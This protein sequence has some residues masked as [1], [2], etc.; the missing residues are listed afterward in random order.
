MLERLWLVCYINTTLAYESLNT[1]HLLRVQLAYAHIFTR[2]RETHTCI[3]PSRT[4]HI[5]PQ[6]VFALL[7]KHE[8]KVSKDDAD[9]VSDLRYTWRSLRKAAL[10]ASERLL[11][12]QPSMQASLEGEVTA[13]VFEADAFVKQWTE[14][15]PM[16]PGLEPL[17][18]AARLRTFAQLFEV[19]DVD[20]GD[21]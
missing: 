20:D 7:A 9:M 5:H 10:E 3:P 19:I 14:E 6:D 18:A 1:Y 11:Q 4:Q 15:G 8:V 21:C 16:V 2:T 12:L 17:E 13:F